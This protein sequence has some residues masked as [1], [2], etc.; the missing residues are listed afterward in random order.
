MYILGVAGLCIAMF[1]ISYT[2]DRRRL[3]NGVFLTVGIILL[4]FGLIVYVMNHLQGN[5]PYIAVLLVLIMLLL[6]PVVVL[7]IGVALVYNGRILLHREGWKLPNLLSMLTGVGI[8]VLPLLVLLAPYNSVLAPLVIVVQLCLAYFGFLFICYLVSSL[9]YNF[10]RPRYRPDFIIVLGS[11]LIRNKVPPLLASRLDQ[12]IAIYLR[13]QDGEPPRIV[14]S[15]G[16]GSDE[17]TAE[18]EAMGQYLL[19]KGI[20]AEHI[21]IENESAN[22]LQN[23]RLSKQKMDDL[24]AGKPYSCIFVTNNFHL[25]R[26]GIYA[27]KAGIQG[28]GIGSRTA[29][30]YLPNAFI[31]EYIAIIVMH[32]RIHLRIIAAGLILALMAVLVLM[33]V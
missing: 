8:L 5:I 31:R 25:F 7:G 14:V 29:L 19:E 33:I 15:G 4:L 32:R 3:Q 20:P 26:A 13:Y 22:T 17:Q 21:I 12:G 23:M 27:R 18:G 9:L 28:D 6:A 2:K 16:Q 11:G 30:Y 10:H 24:M 1:V